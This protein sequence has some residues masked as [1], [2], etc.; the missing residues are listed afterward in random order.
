MFILT[1]PALHPNPN[2]PFQAKLSIS[3]SK[4]CNELIDYIG[5]ENVPVRYGG[6]DKCALGQ[7]PEE[8]SLMEHIQK[9]RAKA[10]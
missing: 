10:S 7:A 4:V 9:N 2:T 3:S 6:A 8:L 5:L 1:P